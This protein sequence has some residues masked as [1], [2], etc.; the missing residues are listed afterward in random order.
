MVFGRE[1]NLRLG[2]GSFQTHEDSFLWLGSRTKYGYDVRGNENEITSYSAVSGGNVVNEV[3]R[4][5][6][7]WGLLA[8]EYQ[9]ETLGAI[10]LDS[11]GTPDDGTPYVGY[12]YADAASPTRL[13]SM[14][15]PNGRVL[16]YVYN[17]GADEALGRVSE[18]A[19]DNGSGS[20]GTVDVAYSYLGLNAIVGQDDVQAGASLGITLDQFGRVS[21]QEWS[22]GGT[23]TALD[24]YIYAYDADGNV[25]SKQNA[26][27]DA[28]GAGLDETYLYNGMNELT[29]I[30]RGTL[31]GGTIAGPATQTWSLDATGNM[32]AVNG[33][34]QSANV[35]N[36]LTSIAGSSV[37]PTYDNDGNMTTTVAPAGGTVAAGAALDCKYD[38]WNRL[39]QVSDAGGIV[40]QYQY[41]GENRR[42]VELANFTGTSPGSITYYFFAGQNPI[43]TRAGAAGSSPQSL[44]TQYQYVWSLR[45]AKTPLLRDSSFAY[46]STTQQWTATT[47]GRIYYLTD[48]NDNV[49]AVFGLSGGAWGAGVIERYVYDPYGT[50]AYYTAAWTGPQS[51]PHTTVA[52][53]VMYA[54]MWLDATTGEYNDE[55]RWYSTATSTFITTDPI[56]ADINPYRYCEDSPTNYVDTHG[57]DISVP[58]D[59]GH[60][61]VPDAYTG[62]NL[63]YSTPGSPNSQGAGDNVTFSSSDVLNNAG[64]YVGATPYQRALLAYTLEMGAELPPA[65]SSDFP[66]I[67]PS[68][69]GLAAPVPGP[70]NYS[71]P[72]SGQPNG[73]PSGGYPAPQLPEPVYGQVHPN[74]PP[75]WAM[76]SAFQNA[77]IPP[78][79][80]SGWFDGLPFQSLIK[81]WEPV[82][83]ESVI[84]EFAPSNPLY[85]PPGFQPWSPP[86]TIHF[87]VH[88][89]CGGELS[90]GLLSQ[91]HITGFA[92]PGFSPS[93]FDTWGTQATWQR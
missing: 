28:V 53:A 40:A 85:T 7:D 37:A 46:N 71:P 48:P 91:I 51:V 88:L 38:A 18:I 79:G 10:A 64:Y 68:P 72:P 8:R 43:E 59:Q 74:L 63:G 61:F 70:G 82:S 4:Q 57:L 58:W 25:V 21:V 65:F 44:A 36:Q 6:N 73:G 20:P 31:S 49:T 32:T 26:V 90:V 56:N 89:P 13:T 34:S 41:D 24:E 81:P 78:A 76:P 23:G 92:M 35:G 62:D 11:S 17:S 39:V 2:E 27:A 66:G 69:Y 12:G 67:S 29:S 54:S 3:F 77:D 87:S 50:V 15:Y 42:V 84:P 9:K 22:A 60:V 83:I 52:N 19:D 75:T 33:V 55:A 14:A 93:N 5:Y 47:V 86:G 80:A 1:K 45:G 30:T 16:D